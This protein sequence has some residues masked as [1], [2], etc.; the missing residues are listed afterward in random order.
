MA[1][2]WLVT[3]IRSRPA[4]EEQQSHIPWQSEALSAKCAWMTALLHFPAAAAAYRVMLMRLLCHVGSV[5]TMAAL[6][7]WRVQRM[8][9]RVWT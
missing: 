7:R 4:D 1:V 6:W 8:S 2:M 3:S 9:Q 5:H